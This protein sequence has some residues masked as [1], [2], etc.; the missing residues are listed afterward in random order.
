MGAVGA[1]QAA[2]LLDDA[3]EDLAGVAERRDPGGDVAERAFPLRARLEGGL[4]PLQLLD[5][6][7][8]RHGD[9]G[10]V[11]QDAEEVGVAGGEL[12]RPVGED[13]Q[14]AKRA[15]LR[16]ERRDGQRAEPDG[17]GLLVL[18]VVCSNRGS[19]W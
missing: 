15:A 19:S 14:R 9:R 10:L 8:V 7:G 16:D 17:A 2:R 3:G 18:I 13:R 1:E 11:G 12:A 6:A 4:R 5:E